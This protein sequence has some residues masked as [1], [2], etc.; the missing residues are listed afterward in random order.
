MIKKRT[1][2]YTDK[3]GD[4]Q[5]DIDIYVEDTEYYE[6]LV[7]AKNTFYETEKIRER[8]WRNSALTE[9]DWMLLPD[10]TFNGELVSGSDYETEIKEYRAKLREYNLTT[11]SRPEKPSWFS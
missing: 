5:T 1:F 2:G 8:E 6:K 3:N 10:A 11:D 4:K 9:C 7:K